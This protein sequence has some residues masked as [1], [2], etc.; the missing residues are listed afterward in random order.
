MNPNSK[1]LVLCKYMKCV[2]TQHIQIYIQY[3]KQTKNTGDPTCVFLMITY[4]LVKG[5]DNFIRVLKLQAVSTTQKNTVLF[6]LTF[7]LL[8]R[9]NYHNPGNNCK[10]Y[11]INKRARGYPMS[12]S[13]PHIVLKIPSL[14]ESLI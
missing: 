4:F 8:S 6:Q 13:I 14:A 9:Y 12:M 10:A 1:S 2:S 5:L 11:A 3:N 7:I